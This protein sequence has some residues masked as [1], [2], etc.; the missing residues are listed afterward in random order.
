[1]KYTLLDPENGYINP[2]GQAED[3][4]LEHAAFYDTEALKERNIDIENT[5]YIVT[6]YTEF[7]QRSLTFELL[8]PQ[9]ELNMDDLG[10]SLKSL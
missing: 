7:Q 3:F 5:E 4:N 1:M 2:Y 8:E 10:Y 6:K 9:T